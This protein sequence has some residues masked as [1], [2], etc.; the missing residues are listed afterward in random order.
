[1][2]VNGTAAVRLA[3][4]G[5]ERDDIAGNTGVIQLLQGGRFELTRLLV[6]GD[7]AEHVDV[8]RIIK[9]VFGNTECRVDPSGLVAGSD[10]HHHLALVHVFGTVVDL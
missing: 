2:H 5:V 4:V 1:M 10:G 7:V 3:I 9:L 8:F 6:V